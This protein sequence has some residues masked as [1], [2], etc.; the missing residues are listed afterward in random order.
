MEPERRDVPL[1]LNEMET[2][3]Q[4]LQNRHPA[5]IESKRVM[6]LEA[7]V[8]RLSEE[9]TRQSETWRD[10]STQV[11]KGYTGSQNAYT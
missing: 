1:Q 9:H 11:R 8:E 6:S 3:Q 7:Q 5:A 10:F 4:E 2:E